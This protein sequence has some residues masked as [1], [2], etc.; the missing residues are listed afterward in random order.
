MKQVKIIFAGLLAL[1]FVSCNR[2][3]ATIR[4]DTM[5]SGEITVAIDETSLPF[6][7]EEVAVFE[8]INEEAT[9]NP[10][11][12]SDEE[13]ISLLL[14]DSVRLVVASRDLTTSEY[15]FIREN[16]LLPRAIRIALDG[17][18]LIIN[19]KNN[20]T[21]MS[22]PTLKKILTGSIKNWSEVFPGSRLGPIRVVFDNPSS[23]TVRYIKDTVCNDEPFS[24]NI[25][26]QLSNEAVI[27]FVS[28]T[29]NALG[30]IS[31]SWISDPTDTLS[32]TFIDKIRVMAVCPY[33]DARED[34]SYL[35]QAAWIALKYY[36][37]TRDIYMI[38]SDAP[39]Y[40]PS[41]FMHFVGGDRGQ[42]II[43]KSGIVPSNPPLRLI[44]VRP[45]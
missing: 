5:T 31:A 38:T 39:S 20:D 7:R 29:P 26:A 23:S 24:D 11:Y 21:L 36:P 1:S 30:I 40:L 25:K 17:V 45:E 32:L 34:N 37:L 6:M 42:R 19:N 14:K 43:L 44:S 33:E 2:Q 12:L 9:I 35:P 41:G 10:L 13:A 16:K 8:S 15:Q 28:K 22:I 27:D 3:P 18:A 4:T